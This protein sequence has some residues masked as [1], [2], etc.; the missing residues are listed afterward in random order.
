MAMFPKSKTFTEEEIERLI[1]YISKNE[2]A[3]NV[4]Y[5][6]QT[7]FYV[8][9]QGIR[10]SQRILFNFDKNDGLIIEETE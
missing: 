7:N 1:E 9:F 4:T 10:D 5:I 3:K 6:G 2:N 8:K